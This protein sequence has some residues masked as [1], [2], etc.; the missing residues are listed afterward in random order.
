MIEKV[1]EIVKKECD[2]WNWK[3]HI[4][5]V[6]KNARLLAQK[7]N[8][9]QELVELGALLHD[10]GRIKFGPE[11]HEIT[12]I[13]EA[14]KILKSLGYSEEVIK[15]VK[16]CVESHR[17]TSDIKPKTI[18]A[19]IVA[20]ADAMAHFDTMLALLQIA[21]IRENNNLERAVNWVYNKIERDWNKKLTLPEA[22]QVMK[23]KYE[24]IK[25][26]LDSIKAYM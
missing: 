14:E 22:K 5:P 8:A 3:F 16:H 26:L 7:L 6:V 25:L 4:L 11:N 19:K 20:N 2:E 15:E 9:D 17:G 24:A 21:L 1:R 10:I 12:G 18:V 23:E 13:P